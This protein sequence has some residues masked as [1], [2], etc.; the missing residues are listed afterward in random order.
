MPELDKQ[1]LCPIGKKPW[2]GRLYPLFGRCQVNTNHAGMNCGAR[3][4]LVRVR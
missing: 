3:F 4:N 2:E 1:F